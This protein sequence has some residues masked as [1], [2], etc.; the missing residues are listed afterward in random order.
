[1]NRNLIT[2]A[3]WWISA[4]MHINPFHTQVSDVFRG[5]RNRT[6]AWNG[7]KHFLTVQM[8]FCWSGTLH[9]LL[10]KLNLFCLVLNERDYTLFPNL[11]SNAL[12]MSN[13]PLL[14]STL[15]YFKFA[16]ASWDRRF[17]HSSH[18]K[19]QSQ[20]FRL[21]R[22]GLLTC[23]KFLENLFKTNGREGIIL[24]T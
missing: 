9:N 20:F 24:E 8:F 2:I 22:G 16:Q 17:Y 10:L 3:S 12:R 23:R 5:Y 6:M 14:D 13:A 4:I 18:I 21:G 7:L 11:L 15:K 19:K 1:M